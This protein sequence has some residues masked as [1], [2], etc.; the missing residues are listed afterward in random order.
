MKIIGTTLNDR[1]RNDVELSCSQNMTTAMNKD[2]A[3]LIT[4]SICMKNAYP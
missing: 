4:N 3:P 1:L 2:V